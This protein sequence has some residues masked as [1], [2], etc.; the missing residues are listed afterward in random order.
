[1]VLLRERHDTIE[2]LTLNRPASANAM[3]PALLG[4]LNAAFDD[5]EED[6]GVRVVVLTG[7]GERHFCA[8]MD[9]GAFGQ[10]SD[11]IPGEDA[12]TSAGRS[13]R[14]LFQRP[15]AK[16]I[17]AAV[18]GAAVGGGFEL[19]LACD[20]VVAAEGARFGLPEVR[21]GLVA[22]GGGTLLGTRIPLALALEIGL[23]G[24]LVDAPRA[25][26]WGLVNRVVA[27]DELMEA[28][29]Q[30]AAAVTA[31]G[32]LAV[33]TTKMLMRRAVTQDPESGW[34][35][36]AEL[37]AVFGSEDAREGAAAFMEKRPPAWKGR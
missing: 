26:Q 37:A 29:L 34:G 9:L 16:P 12:G 6:D 15:C 33:Q 4:A 22:G 28:A 23:T 25:A 36:S 21:R 19:V 3:D 20:L 1:M 5:I 17:V 14:D 13:G 35:S 18:N 32:P 7:A 8:G 2:V 30:L 31:N 27:A 24:Q 11:G 10:Q